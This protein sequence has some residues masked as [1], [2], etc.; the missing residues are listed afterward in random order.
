MGSSASSA[1]PASSEVVRQPRTI[2]QATASS[3]ASTAVSTAATGS[4]GSPAVNAPGEN[5]RSS[6]AQPHRSAARPARRT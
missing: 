2:R 4:A 6:S 3:R 5:A 1:T